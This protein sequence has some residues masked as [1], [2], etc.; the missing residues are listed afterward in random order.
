[1]LVSST[2]RYLSRVN[3]AKRSTKQRP[4]FVQK[5]EIVIPHAHVAAPLDLLDAPERIRGTSF[6]AGDDPEDLLER[7]LVTG[8]S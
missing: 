4:R 3:S 8:D 2:T 1:M 7:G 6:G 5:L